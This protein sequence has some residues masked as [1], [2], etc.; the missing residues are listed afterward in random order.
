MVELSLIRHH[1]Q[2]RNDTTPD[3]FGALRGPLMNLKRQVSVSDRGQ[4]NDRNG[5]HCR[6]SSSADEKPLC[7][8]VVSAAS[9]RR[10]PE[11]QSDLSWTSLALPS[12]CAGLVAEVEHPQAAIVDMRP[13]IRTVGRDGLELHAGFVGEVTDGLVAAVR[14]ERRSRRALRRAGSFIFR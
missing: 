5:A 8:V 9:G 7:D 10:R 11:W 12:F 14:V 3:A 6:R 1:E 13:M 2:R 4:L